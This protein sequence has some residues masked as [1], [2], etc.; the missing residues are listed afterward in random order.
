MKLSYKYLLPD[1]IFNEPR[2]KI[3]DCHIS[4]ALLVGSP[5]PLSPDLPF[6]VPTKLGHIIMG[7]VPTHSPTCLGNRPNPPLQISYVYMCI[8][9]PFVRISISCLRYYKKPLSHHTSDQIYDQ[10]PGRPTVLHKQ[11]F[12]FARSLE[13]INHTFIPRAIPHTHK[14]FI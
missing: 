7:R 8:G 9:I 11:C 2:A 13:A 12:D 14:D 4:S 3:I 6:I 10:V 5:L 1:P